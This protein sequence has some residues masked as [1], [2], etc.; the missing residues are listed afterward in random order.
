MTIDR[1]F[2]QVLAELS[3]YLDSPPPLGSPEH[4][5]FVDLIAEV[6]CHAALGSEHPHAEQ[7]DQLGAK[8]ERV[9]R[10]RIAER[11]ARDLAP[12]GEGMAPMLGWDFHTRGG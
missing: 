9:V 1:H 10:R 5:R 6:G 11:H 8:I 2:E 7:I 12:G 4:L 3:P